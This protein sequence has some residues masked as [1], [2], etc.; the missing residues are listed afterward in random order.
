MLA[1]SSWLI[2]DRGL[3]G[4]CG[5]GSCNNGSTTGRG[6]EQPW[7]SLATWIRPS[8]AC[9]SSINGSPPGSATGSTSGSL[10]P[11][12]IAGAATHGSSGS[13]MVGAAA[14]SESGSATAASGRRTGTCKR[15]GLRPWPWPWPRP[16]PRRPEVPRCC[17]KNALLPFR[18]AVR[19]DADA[20]AAGSESG[21]ATAT[22]AAAGGWERLQLP[23]RGDGSE[24]ACCVAPR[25]MAHLPS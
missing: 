16:G 25:P 4:G 8:S 11:R 13:G 7:G 20:A 12:R 18:V 14:G 21:S 9:S 5:R 2:R 17:G 23:S 10:R 22:S 6:P 3:C 15:C 19:E 24:K 1:S